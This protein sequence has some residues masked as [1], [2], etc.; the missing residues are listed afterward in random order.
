MNKTISE[1]I[2]NKLHHAETIA[3]INPNKSLEISEEVYALA[4]ANNLAL[5][6]G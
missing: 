5:E 6:E 3:S 2:Y 1:E 4:K